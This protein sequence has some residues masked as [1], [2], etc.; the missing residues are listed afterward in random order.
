M[1]ADR[2]RFYDRDQ[3]GSSFSDTERVIGKLEEEGKVAGPRYRNECGKV[4]MSK[5][6]WVT[7]LTAV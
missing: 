1:R 5:R 4:L 2:I 7:Q 3:K 6:L